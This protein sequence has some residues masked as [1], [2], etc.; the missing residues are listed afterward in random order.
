M[1]IHEV[2]SGQIAQGAELVGNMASTI[3][4]A[5]DY[6]GYAAKG[7]QKAA[8]VVGKGSQLSNAAGS[9]AKAA[10]AL[11]NIGGKLMKFLPG[12]GLVAAGADAVR[13]ASAGD[14][15]GAAISAA[16][17]AASFIPVVGTAASLGLTAANA[18]RDYYN[19]GTL[20]ASTDQLAAASGKSAR[21]GFPQVAAAPQ[22]AAQAPAAQTVAQAGTPKPAAAQTV[23]QAGAAKPPATQTVAQAGAARPVANQTVAQAAAPKQAVAEE[24]LS[25]LKNAG[26]R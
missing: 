26:I 4:D 19:H 15:T 20:S 18:A 6:A 3:A 25:I 17:G 23:A 8:N 10:P 21:D 16:G 2:T 12:V 1:R 13:R 22:P 24:L 5:G 14:Y 9:V 7:V 11:T